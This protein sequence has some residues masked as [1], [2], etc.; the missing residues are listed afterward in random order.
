MSQQGLRQASVR[1]V[2]GKAFDYNGDWHAL[3]DLAGIAAGDFNG[4]MLA[5]INRRLSANYTSVNDAM[6]ALATA[7][8]ATNFSSIGT[9]NATLLGPELLNPLDFTS[10]WTAVGTAAPL[11]PMSFSVAGTTGEG[12]H[13]DIFTP[14]KTYRVEVTYTKSAGASL[15]S[16][17]NSTSSARLIASSSSNSATLLATMLMTDSKLY[18]RLSGAADTVIVG[19]ASVR[20]AL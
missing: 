3:F 15:L 4:R 7:N 9:F 5:W 14:G 8:G 16:L 1:A 20:E 12:L 11:S 17:T 2:T 19:S 10:G 6:A 13:K 18:F